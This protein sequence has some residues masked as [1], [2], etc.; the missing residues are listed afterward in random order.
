MKRVMCLFLV[1]VAFIAGV[2]AQS[3]TVRSDRSLNADIDDYK[4]FYWSSQ[5]DAWLDEGGIYFLNDLGMK[6]IIRDAVKGE[7]MGLGYQLQSHEPDIIVN[8]RVF[9][10]PVTLKGYEGYGTSYWDD[11]RYRTADNATTY[12][13]EAG[14]L[15]V[16]LADR[17]NGRVIW[18]GFASGLIEN[19]VFI[20]EEGRIR[21]AV[22]L[23]FN[24]FDARAKEYTRK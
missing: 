8:F 9:D 14:T 22:N 16:S 19:N 10:K 18:Q 23:I 12:D 17:K 21:E 7:L 20:K 1:S 6:A 11:E 2:R 15:L 13:V 4:T 3:I 5:A 24:E